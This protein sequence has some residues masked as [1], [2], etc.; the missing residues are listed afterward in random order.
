MRPA[1]LLS[2][3]ACASISANAQWLNHPTP[4]IPR[5]PDGKPDL[6]APP[7]HTPDGKPDLSGIWSTPSD[8]YNNNIAADLKPGDVMP[9]ADA[10]YQQ[11]LRDFGKDSMITLCLPLGP[12]AT[13]GP[14]RDFKIVQSP[15]LIVI[16]FDDLTFR[17]VHMDGRQL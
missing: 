11:R 15:T 3:F 5:T 17:Q 8:R 9:W 12:A 4:G 1:F 7:P 13:T 16:L 14:Y 2:L 10:L 6:Y